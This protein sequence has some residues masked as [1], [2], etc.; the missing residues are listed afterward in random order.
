MQASSVAP[1]VKMSSTRITVFRPFT[2]PFTEKAPERFRAERLLCRGL[3]RAE[4]DVPAERNPGKL[5][6]FLREQF[7]LVVASLQESCAVDRHGDQ[8]VCPERKDLLL[9]E[10]PDLLRI[11]PRV[12]LPAAVFEARDAFPGS[13]VVAE[14]SDVPAEAPL[15][16]AAVG[17][18]LCLLIRQRFSAAEAEGLDD[19]DELFSAVRMDAFPVGTIK[20]PV[21]NNAAP[22]VDTL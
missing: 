6:Q 8:G 18:I 9:P 11:R 1:V 3:F 10:S 7:G 14:G 15:S 22:G 12:A 5:R 2:E 20:N 19:G 4:E 17:T 21:A 16:S 13:F